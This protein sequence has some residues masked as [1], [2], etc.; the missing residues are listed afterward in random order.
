MPA[1]HRLDEFLVAAVRQLCGAPRA[2][3]SADELPRVARGRQRE[4]RQLVARE[5]RE[6]R[7]V[8]GEVGRQA[9]RAHLVGEAEAAEVLH[10]A[11]LRGVGRGVARGAGVLVD[12]HHRDAAPAELDRERE[13]ARTA[14]DD[15]YLGLRREH[16]PILSGRRVVRWG[17]RTRRAI[18]ATLGDRASPTERWPSIGSHRYSLRDCG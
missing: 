3:Q 6:I 11:R 13:A 1:Q 5:A 16:A 4:A 7:D 8:R 17:C 15:H 12:Q 2:A 9:E 10:G 14:A 18:G